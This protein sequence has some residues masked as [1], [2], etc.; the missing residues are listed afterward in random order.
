ML[1][2]AILISFV[3]EAIWTRCP[4]CGEKVSL[5][6]VYCSRDRG[7][8]RDRSRSAAAAATMTAAKVVAVA[9]MTA[10]VR[11]LQVAAVAAAVRSLGAMRL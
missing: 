4:H 11:H 7:R 1:D 10:M 6:K 9:G 5:T 8:N 3:A 2:L